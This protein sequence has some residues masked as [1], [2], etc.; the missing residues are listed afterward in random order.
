M[1]RALYLLQHLL[2]R[3]SKYN[4]PNVLTLDTLPEVLQRWWRR[5][6]SKPLTCVVQ[7]ESGYHLL[8]L[9][10]QQHHVFVIIN[11]LQPSEM[12]AMVTVVKT[13]LPNVLVYPV[14]CPL[15]LQESKQ[16]LHWHILVHVSLA[17]Q[18]RYM[19]LLC[20]TVPGSTY[21]AQLLRH[22]VKKT[23]QRLSKYFVS[24]EPRQLQGGEGNEPSKK[25]IHVVSWNANDNFHAALSRLLCVINDQRLLFFPDVLCLQEINDNVVLKGSQQNRLIRLRY[26]HSIAFVLEVVEANKFVLRLYRLQRPVL[27]EARDHTR[28]T[29]V[30]THL[31]S[32]TGYLA[33][34]SMYGTPHESHFKNLYI[35]VKQQPEHLHVVD[36]KFYAIKKRVPRLAKDVAVG[37]AVANNIDNPEAAVDMYFHDGAPVWTSVRKR[38]ILFDKL[39]TY[40]ENLEA[41]DRSAFFPQT[42]SWS[43]PVQEVQPIR[44]RRDD[45]TLLFHE[46]LW[47]RGMLCLFMDNFVLCTFHNIQADN[48]C[49]L[50]KY[51]MHLEQQVGLPFLLIGDFNIPVQQFEEFQGQTLLQR[52]RTVLAWPKHVTSK[53][54]LTIDYALYS[55]SK[56]DVKSVDAVSVLD[57]LTCQPLPSEQVSYIERA[58]TDESTGPG[59]KRVPWEGNVLVRDHSVLIA[60]VDLLL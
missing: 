29:V 57:T 26:L 43:L 20:D 4:V 5:K 34:Q 3:I 23:Q 37:V 50:S 11:S 8:A 35:L 1:L 10:K 53:N 24:S 17:M 54:D 19:D 22:M 47:L 44:S 30:P 51:V 59:V 56:F 58:P 16:C 60:N 27:M 42:C 49:A 41:R 45:G 25:R 28:K 33:E 55:P 31:V 15:K 36:C 13:T 39:D 21:A 2:P 38:Q 7:H 6:K 18:S 9:Q 14:P 32:Y 52:S 12:D 48:W 40:F 46:N